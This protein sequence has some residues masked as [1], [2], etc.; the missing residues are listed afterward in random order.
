MFPSQLALPVSWDR[1]GESPSPD[2]LEAVER[3]NAGVVGFL[4]QG[5]DL[6][7]MPRSADERLAEALA[8]LRVKLDMIIEMLG[9][10]SYRHVA[11]PPICEIEFSLTQMAWCSARPLRIGEWSRIQLY[12]HPTF[13]EPVVAFGRVTSC[14]EEGP[15]R[16][17][18]VKADVLEMAAGISESIA[19]LAF[20]MQRHQRALHSVRTPAMRET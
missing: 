11:L 5:V 7:A 13:R 20:L 9:K 19:R 2:V 8:P 10:L 6:E 15:D 18:R 16:G 12:F 3:S 1:L 14:A 17:Y 4:L